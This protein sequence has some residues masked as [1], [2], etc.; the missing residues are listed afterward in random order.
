LD[1]IGWL[2]VSI[3]SQKKMKAEKTIQI[4]GKDVTMRYCCAAETGYES[5]S[6]KSSEIFAP[7]VAERD[8]EGKPTK[9]EP[10][11]AM[12][13]DYIKLA[14]AAIIANYESK[15]QE[16]PIK[17][18]DIMYNAGPKEI[19]N[20][21]NAIVEIRSIWYEIPS[22]VKPETDEKPDDKPKNA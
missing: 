22:V 15:K 9:I 3:K 12:A 4:C 13:D 7:T 10:P 5:I 17:P 14:I 1:P 19:S 11:K 6:G 20:L 18:D 2:G 16:L 8:E 21:L